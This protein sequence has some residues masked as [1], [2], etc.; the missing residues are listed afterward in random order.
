MPKVP[1]KRTARE[2]FVIAAKATSV[3]APVVKPDPVSAPVIAGKT[4]S[5]LAPA[6][7][8]K[9]APVPAPVHLSR[10][11]PAIPVPAALVPAAP[12]SSQPSSLQAAEQRARLI[13]QIDLMH[14]ARHFQFADCKGE[15]CL[16]TSHTARG[17]AVDLIQATHAKSCNAEGCKVR[18]PCVRNACL[19][20][21]RT[22]ALTL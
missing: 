9:S 11:V 4:M 22:T 17:A 19:Q 2:A 10:L 5:V 7:A 20:V 14:L 3:L 6:S 12:A 18:Y 16:C 15:G 21:L 13:A 8:L 1:T